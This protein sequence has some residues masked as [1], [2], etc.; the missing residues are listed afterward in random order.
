MSSLNYVTWFWLK[1][2]C[3][4][5]YN[6]KQTEAINLQHR[7]YDA[8]MTVCFTTAQHEGHSKIREFY[9]MFNLLY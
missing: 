6:L 2:T 8:Y 5:H 3:Q 9:E 7:A 1:E 4:Q